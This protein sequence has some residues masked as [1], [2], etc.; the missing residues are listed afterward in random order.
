ML[1]LCNS[2]SFFDNVERLRV[3]NIFFNLRLRYFWEHA[4]VSAPEVALIEDIEEKVVEKL[5]VFQ[6]LLSLSSNLFQLM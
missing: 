3:I 6:D 5:D 4:I 2:H 1:R